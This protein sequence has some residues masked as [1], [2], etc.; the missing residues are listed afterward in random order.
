MLQTRWLWFSLY[1]THIPSRDHLRW[2]LLSLDTISYTPA[3]NTQTL[4]LRFIRWPL[5]KLELSTVYAILLHTYQHFT[6]DS[7]TKLLVHFD[8]GRVHMYPFEYATFLFRIG[9]PSEHTWTMK[10]TTKTKLSGNAL[11]MWNFWKQL[12]YGMTVWQ[13]VAA[14]SKTITSRRPNVSLAQVYCA[15]FV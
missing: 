10:T 6:Y 13:C 3:S 8:W 2:V 7:E 1:C 9:L 11:Q 14:V 4:H 12:F 5:S 15:C